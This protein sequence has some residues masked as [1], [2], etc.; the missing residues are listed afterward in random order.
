MEA[1]KPQGRIAY[2]AYHDARALFVLLRW[3]LLN[4]EL[5]RRL[6]PLA[7]YFL[8]MLRILSF[9]SIAALAAAPAPVHAAR[10]GDASFYGR[11]DGFA[12]RTMANGQPMNPSASITAHRSLPFGTRLLVV[13]QDNG[14]STQVVVTDRGPYAGGRILDLSAGAFSRIASPSQGI[15]RVCYRLV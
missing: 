11:G 14:R 3:A 5:A 15:A 7:I 6:A 4:P 8:L 9:L 2:K 12:G 13:N 10:C 1:I